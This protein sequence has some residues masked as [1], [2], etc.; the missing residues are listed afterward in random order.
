MMETP[1]AIF[2]HCSDPLTERVLRDLLGSAGYR[3]AEKDARAVLAD[4][5]LPPDKSR[6]LRQSGLPVIS[7]KIPSAEAR[8]R[9]GALLARLHRAL[10]NDMAPSGVIA[11]GPFQ[12]DLSDLMLVNKQ[13]SA[14]TA[15]TE[16]ERDILLRLYREKGIVDRRTL[17]QD[18]WGYATQVETHTLE[19]HI[20]RLRQKMENDPSAPVFL[21]TEGNGYRL[22]I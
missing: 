21:V 7:F 2:L 10:K 13:T 5:T 3:I 14:H 19:T 22:N 9:P 8:L 11:L 20:Y 15:L 6:T 16:K 12:L 18:V 17:L 1:A 4:E